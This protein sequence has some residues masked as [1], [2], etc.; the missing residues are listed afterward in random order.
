[1]KNLSTT[2]SEEQGFGVVTFSVTMERKSLFYVVNLIIPTA[3]LGFIMLLTF[4]LPAE[5][6]KKLEVICFIS[7][8]ICTLRVRVVCTCV[9]YT[10]W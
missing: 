5:S 8:I 1:M 10:H 3:A 9:V 6:G 2:F 7:A 4:L